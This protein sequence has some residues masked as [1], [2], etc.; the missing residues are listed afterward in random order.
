MDGFAYQTEYSFL[1]HY[2]YRYLKR[3]VIVKLENSV[4]V[5]RYGDHPSNLRFGI[6]P[7]S[8]GD[9]S[10]LTI[11]LDKMKEAFP[12]TSL[13]TRSLIP[14][15]ENLLFLKANVNTYY[16]G[17]KRATRMGDI[18]YASTCHLS[19][20]LQGMVKTGYGELIFMMRVHNCVR[21]PVVAIKPNVRAEEDVIEE[22]EDIY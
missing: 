21:L 22:D 12:G 8:D 17:D 16:C 7:I 11:S 18:P 6:G 5:L 4:R 1:N 14:T 9:K 15:G 3:P 20:V 10:R 19:I 13:S 2:E